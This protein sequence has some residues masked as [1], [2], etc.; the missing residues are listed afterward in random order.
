[1]EICSLLR[2]QA[3]SLVIKV[4]FTLIVVVCQYKSFLPKYR[5][6]ISHFSNNFISVVSTNC[7]VTHTVV[8]I[9]GFKFSWKCNEN[10]E[11]GNLVRDI[12]H[13]LFSITTET[14][15]SVDNSSLSPLPFLYIKCFCKSDNNTFSYR[16]MQIIHSLLYGLHS[17]CFALVYLKC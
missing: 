12:T 15:T 14:F 11:Q 17:L 7:Y 10:F 8:Y 5:A 9:G 3:V 16:W 2:L 6:H 1:V 13:C 4:R